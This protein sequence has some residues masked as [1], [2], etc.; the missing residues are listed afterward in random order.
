MRSQGRSSG[1]TPPNWTCLCV[2]ES[3]LVDGCFVRY[4]ARDR[5]M[6]HRDADGILVRGFD[7]RRAVPPIG[8]F[9]H[10]CDR[11]EIHQRQRDGPVA[12]RSRPRNDSP[13][14]SRVYSWTTPGG[15]TYRYCDANCEIPAPDGRGYNP[16]RKSLCENSNSAMWGGLCSRQP[17]SGRLLFSTPKSLLVRKLPTQTG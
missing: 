6:V 4:F 15:L 8:F 17:H 11:F 1:E 13:A 14:G 3:G 5:E 10:R 12:F 9:V 16:W 2:V 7:L